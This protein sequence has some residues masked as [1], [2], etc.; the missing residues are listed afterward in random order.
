MKTTHRSILFMSLFAFFSPAYADMSSLNLGLDYTLRGIVIQNNDTDANTSDNLGYYSHQARVSMNGW[1][2]K[3]VEAGLRVQ[4]VNVW[5]LEG[6]TRTPT[7]RYPS[8]D[9]SPW[10]E[11]IYVRMPNLIGN[12]VD[13]TIGRQPLV[14]GDGMIVSDDGLGFNAIRA[15]AKFPRGLGMDLFTAKI[16]ESLHENKDSDLNGAILSL[17]QGDNRWELGWI[18]ETHDSP[19]TYT[20]GLSTVTANT[21]ARTFYDVRLFGNLK[22]AYYKLEMALVNGNTR[23]EDKDIKISGIAEKIELGAQSDTARFG[24]FGVKALY[25]SGSGDD[26]G[27]PDKDESFRPTFAKRWNGLQRAGWGQH[28]GATLS[29]AYDSQEPFSPTATGLPSGASGIKTLGFGVFTVQWVKWTGSIDYFTYDSRVKVASENSLG[30][31][32]DLGI[33]FRY[34]GDVIFKLSSATFFPGP[35]YGENASKVTRYTAETQIHF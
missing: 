25:A 13:L 9:G 15:K 31:E 34:S 4:S 5:G 24:R 32:L 17:D 30:A 20:L 21:I 35:I 19:S 12:H 10:I 2:S 3:E 11:H 8:A 1:L 29:D 28:Y 27:T 33:D 16:S 14:L 23:V 22:D 26:A 7:S 18:R 6:S